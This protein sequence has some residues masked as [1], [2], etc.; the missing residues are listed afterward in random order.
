MNHIQIIIPTTNVDLQDVAIAMLSEIG[1]DGFEQ[2]DNE[3]KAYIFEEQFDEAATTTLLQ[4]QQLT[5]TKNIVEEQNWNELWESNFQPVF[6][7][8]FVGI[9]AAFHQPLQGFEHEIVITPKMSFGTGHH[10]TTFSVMQLMREINFTNKTVFDFG[11]GTGILAILAE[12]LGAVNILAVDNDDWC[13]ENS[14][15]NIERNNCKHITIE[16]VNDATTI[17]PFDVVIA[18]INKNIIQDNFELIHQAC[19][20]GGQIVLSGLLIEDEED[21]LALSNA[22]KWQHIKTLTKGAWIAM[23]YKL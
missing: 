13:I 12:K 6:V 22:K 15:E 4:E 17:N 23:L 20:Q 18:N 1:Y 5:F 2:D 21:I 7:D 8:D 9:R 11:S 3:V 14:Q 16:K 10:A 19:K